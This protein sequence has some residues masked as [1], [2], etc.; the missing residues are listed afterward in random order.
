MKPLKWALSTAL[1]VGQ[2]EMIVIDFV[3]FR[4]TRLRTRLNHGHPVSRM[5]HLSHLCFR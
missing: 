2:V 5:F 1:H 4:T 3:G